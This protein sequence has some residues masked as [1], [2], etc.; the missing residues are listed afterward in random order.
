MGLQ[1]A[2]AHWTTLSD[3]NHLSRTASL[4]KEHVVAVFFDL[5]K[6]YDTTWRYGILKDLHELGFRGNLP[7]FI[8]SFLTN[9]HFRVQIG[10][11]LSNPHV[12]ELGVPQETILSVTLLSIKINSI[13]KVIDPHVFRR[14]YVDD[15][16][17]CYR[18]GKHE[19]N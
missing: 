12:Q 10:T 18:G 8:S 16:C 17:I 4:K 6:A 5:E 19:Y 11:T 7:I 15:L 1:E 3:L 14:L 2:K 13:I 9:R